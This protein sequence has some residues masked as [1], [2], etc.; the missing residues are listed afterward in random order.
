MSS[1]LIDA[2]ESGAESGRVLI[3]DALMVIALPSGDGSATANWS[4]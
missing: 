4:L 3:T 1:R 2:Q